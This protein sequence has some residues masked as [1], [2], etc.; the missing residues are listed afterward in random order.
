MSEE[1]SHALERLS[2]AVATLENKTLVH[3]NEQTEDIAVRDGEL[4][5]IKKL[6]DQAV[7]LLQT[8]DEETDE[9]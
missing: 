1:L 4:A 5:E 2:A 3:Q 8:K 6:V 7:D 9:H